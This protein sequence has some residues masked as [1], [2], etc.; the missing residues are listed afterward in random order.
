MPLGEG[1][2][3]VPKKPAVV[4]KPIRTVLLGAVAGFMVGL[5]SVG[6]GSIIVVGL[7]MM[8][9]ALQASALVGTDLVQAIPLVGSAAAGHMLFGSFSFAVAF[10]LLFGAIP[11][12]W[13]GAQV[14]T[15]APGGIIRR[16]LAVLLLSSSLKLLGFSNEIV[17]LAAVAAPSGSAA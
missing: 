13:F 7:L 12:A 14:S 1:I 4:L 10:S 11:G 16:V 6:A 15:R 2:A 17:L 8:H 9:P 5:T 3:G